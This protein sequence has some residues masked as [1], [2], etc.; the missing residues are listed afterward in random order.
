MK[1]SILIPV[2]N[3]RE[4]IEE[5]ISRV[6][7]ADIGSVKKEIILVDDFS[8]D[9]T[10]EIIRGIKGVKAFFHNKNYGKGYAIRTAINNAGGDIVIVQDADLEY[11]PN[12]Y[13]KL[14]TPII[15]NKT[16]VV[17][18]SRILNKKNDYSYLR[19]YLGGRLVTFFT[20]LLYH[21][22]IT[23]EPTCYKVFRSDVIKKVNLKCVGFEFC[24]EVTAKIAKMGIK[25][26]EIP[27]SYK[28]RS[29]EEGKKIKWKDGLIAFWTLFKYKFKG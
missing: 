28:A 26:V 11:D 22:K 17:Y 9:G 5:L 24:P 29:R 10:R 14:I 2:Y 8:S 1:L 23:D 7:M 6:K 15:E 13:L 16:V 4:T 27:I 19:F 18:G 20:N 25:I 12:D 3:E 21:T